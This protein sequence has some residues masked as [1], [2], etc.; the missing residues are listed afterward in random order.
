MSF[1]PN[2]LHRPKVLPR[3]VPNQGEVDALAEAA[4][5]RLDAEFG[6]VPESQRVNIIRLIVLIADENRRSLNLPRGWVRSVMTI[7]EDRGQ[8]TTASSVRW[9]RSSIAAGLLD[10]V[11]DAGMDED[12]VDWIMERL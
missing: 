11:G 5:V 8:P 2:P 1:V 4:R 12:A 9:Y 7:L 10:P 6:W 3:P